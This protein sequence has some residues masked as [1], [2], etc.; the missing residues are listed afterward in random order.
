[1]NQPDP[2]TPVHEHNRRAWDT[3][4]R[5]NQRFTRPAPDEDFLDP[6]RKVDEIGWLGGEIRGQNVLL[7]QRAGYTV[8]VPKLFKLRIRYP[9]A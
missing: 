6:L 8:V 4:V 2:T 1:M 7:V 5:E 3:L 9:N